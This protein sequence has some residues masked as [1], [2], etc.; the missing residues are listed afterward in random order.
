MKAHQYQE[1]CPT[2]LAFVNNGMVDI[3]NDDKII[4]PSDKV[5]FCLGTSNE[6]NVPKPQSHI[7]NLLLRVVQPT[8]FDSNDVNVRITLKAGGKQSFV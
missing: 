7:P 2:S 8:A 1:K 5:Q 6:N 3:F 4:P